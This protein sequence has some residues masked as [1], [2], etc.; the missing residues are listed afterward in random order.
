M[1]LGLR[2]HG[3]LIRCSGGERGIYIY[4]YDSSE[5]VMILMGWGRS[6]NTSGTDLNQYPGFWHHCKKK[7]RDESENSERMKI[8]CKEKS[9]HSRKGSTG[10][11]KRELHARFGGAIFMGFCNQQVKY[12]WRF[13]EK[14]EDF[15]KLWCH[16]LLHW[17]MGVCEL[18]WCW[19]ACDW[20][21]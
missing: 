10:V 12:S 21:C 18:S 9:I 13:L 16:P 6:T 1:V 20:V 14:V 11:L 2:S 15:S 8:Y 5:V 17:I 7:F 3:A 4:I 19:W